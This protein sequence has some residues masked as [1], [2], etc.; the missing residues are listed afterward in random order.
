MKKG[1]SGPC[2]VAASIHLLGLAV[3]AAAEPERALAREEK[4]SSGRLRMVLVVGHT[5]F[6]PPSRAKQGGGNS[7][8]VVKYV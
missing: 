7:V 8:N 2:S 4:A 1:S 3:A 6:S 5:A